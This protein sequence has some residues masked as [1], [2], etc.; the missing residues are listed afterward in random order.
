MVKQDKDYPRY[1]MFATRL[2]P[3]DRKTLEEIK[4]YYGLRTLADAVRLAL[5]VLRFI[6]HNGYEFNV[7]DILEDYQN[8]NPDCYNIVIG[9]GDKKKE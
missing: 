9:G 4:K 1:P 8:A 3:D 5:R 2:R 7:H 6:Y